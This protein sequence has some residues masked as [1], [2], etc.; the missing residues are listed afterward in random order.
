MLKGLVQ[1]GT[2]LGPWKEQLRRNPF[3]VKRAFVASHA[4][5]QLLPETDPRPAGGRPRGAVELM[6]GQTL[7]S[8]HFASTDLGQGATVDSYGGECRSQSLTPQG[9]R[10]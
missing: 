1:S 9:E 4:T 7:T 10:R 3:D 2:P 8:R 6:R 5:R